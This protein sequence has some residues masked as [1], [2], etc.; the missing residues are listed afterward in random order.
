MTQGVATDATTMMCPTNFMAPTN[1]STDSLTV[2]CAGTFTLCY[3]IK[4]GDPKNPL[5]TDCVMAEAC[6]T[7][8]YP[9]PD[10]A[11][12]NPVVQLPDLPGWSTD[13]A[14]TA[15]A[16]QFYDTGGYGQ[17]SVNGQSTECE[18]VSKVFQTVTYCPLSCGANPSAPGCAGCMPGG[19]GSF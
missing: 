16:Q 2:D 8:D 19:G 1:W 3:T 4:A 18:L 11:G 13:A 17:M 5:P 12:T 7:A 15:C 6:V 14:Q 10:D 9:G